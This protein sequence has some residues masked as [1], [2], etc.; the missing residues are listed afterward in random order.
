MDVLSIANT[1]S[2]RKGFIYRFSG[3]LNGQN[4]TL[5]VTEKLSLLLRRNDF[6]SSVV[7]L[8]SGIFVYIN[9]Q[10]PEG[11]ETTEF[12]L[13]GNIEQAIAAYSLQQEENLKSLQPEP[14]PT[15]EPTQESEPEP[16]PEPTQESEEQ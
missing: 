12:S 6:I 16:T 1:F 9:E 4:A 14:E 11:T 13:L 7:Q 3:N 10:F 8:Q 15:P 2:V 5:A